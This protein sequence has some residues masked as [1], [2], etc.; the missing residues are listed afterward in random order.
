MSALVTDAGGRVEGAELVGLIPAAV[1]ATVP[2]DRRDALGLSEAA[3][4]ESR[5]PELN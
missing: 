5:L 2:S 1:L 3:T 4:V